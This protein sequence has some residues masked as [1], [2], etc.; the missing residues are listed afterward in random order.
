M[1]VKFEHLSEIAILSGEQVFSSGLRDVRVGRKTN[2]LSMISKFNMFACYPT[3]R[4]FDLTIHGKKPL[5]EWRIVTTSQRL[6]FEFNKYQCVHSPGFRRDE[7]IGGV[8]AQQKWFLQLENGN[9]DCFV[10]MS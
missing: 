8:I 3:G 2:V 10:I 9:S 1:V 6:A 5:K 4:G 7:I